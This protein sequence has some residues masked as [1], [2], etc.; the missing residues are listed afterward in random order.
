MQNRLLRICKLLTIFI[1]ELNY[2]L[3]VSYGEAFDK[4]RSVF[5][6][7]FGNLFVGKL[8]VALVAEDGKSTIH[9]ATFGTFG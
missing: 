5:G 8:F 6:G 2:H 1:I 3:T 9:V 4:R 7:E